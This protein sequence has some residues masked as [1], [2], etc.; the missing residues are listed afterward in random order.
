MAST[1]S[2]VRADIRSPSRQFADLFRREIAPHVERLEAER[3]RQRH[4]CLAVILATGGVALGTLVVLWPVNRATGFVLALALGALG[5]AL[6]GY[7]RNQFSSEL[8]KLVMPAICQAIGDLTHRVGGQT[9]IDLEEL[10]GLGLL[11]G[12]DR[13]AIDDVFTGRH[14]DT[15]FTM[16]EARLRRRGYGRRRRARTVF[17]GLI[18]QIE[19]PKPIPARIMIARD[20]GAIGNRLKGWLK[21]I[22]GMERI[23]LPHP[24]FEERFELYADRPELAVETVSPDFCDAMVALAEAHDGK[25]LQAAFAGRHFYLAM[26]RSGDQFRLGSVFRPLDDLEDEAGR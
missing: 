9:G 14:R 23:A 25:P 5:Y 22:G 26:P 16:L 2:R 10:A 20:S 19:T 1:A 11:P 13:R 15:G 12:H 4:S 8:R 18:L 7:L 6:Q 3:R 17:R 21:Q 24:A